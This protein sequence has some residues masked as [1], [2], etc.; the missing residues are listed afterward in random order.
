MVWKMDRYGEPYFDPLDKGLDG[1]YDDFG[2]EYGGGWKWRDE[3]I[4]DHIR[5]GGSITTVPGLEWGN[6]S[7]S[8][9]LHPRRPCREAPDYDLSKALGRDI[10]LYEKALLY[11]R[12]IALDIVDAV[13]LEASGWRREYLGRLGARL[14]AEQRTL[15][16][17]FDEINQIGER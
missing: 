9:K 11:D 12:S 1:E 5:R 15:N 7:Q 10:A 4:A 3:V 17:L 8:E 6:Q 14:A 13:M 2:E 16:P